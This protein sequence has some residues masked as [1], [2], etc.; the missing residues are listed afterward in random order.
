MTWFGALTRKLGIY[1]AIRY[2]PIY[3]LIQRLRNPGY[4][5]ALQRE[6]RFYRQL[7]GTGNSGLVFDVGANVGDKTEVFSR[8]ARQV[9][10]FEPDPRLAAHLKLRFQRQKNVVVEGCGL[11]D[12][13]GVMTLH[14][15]G[16]GSAY[17]TLCDRRHESIANL[18]PGHQK[19]DVLVTTLDQMIKRHGVPDYIKVDVEGHEVEVFAGLSRNVRLVSFEANLPEFGSETC[20]VVQ[21]LDALS[22]GTVRFWAVAA[23][24]AEAPTDFPLTA[25]EVCKLV[26]DDRAPAYLEFFARI[27]Q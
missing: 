26:M 15:Y 2:S 20:A 10:S 12:R 13:E 14:A 19:I 23:E 3:P 21:R 7:L 6:E 17:N 27:N 18:H 24:L 5:R 4:F 9:V 22:G 11:S 25:E 8:V 1:G 16:G